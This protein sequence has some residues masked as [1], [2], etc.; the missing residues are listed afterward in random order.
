[1]QRECLEKDR[2]IDW[3]GHREDRMLHDDVSK[4]EFLTKCDSETCMN[5][6]R[7]GD[8]KHCASGLTMRVSTSVM[9]KV[10]V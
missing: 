4:E 5:V 8:Y 7:E 6:A 9:V 2:K 3:H 10:A 1:M